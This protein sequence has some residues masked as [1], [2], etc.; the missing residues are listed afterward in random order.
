MTMSLSRVPI[1][2]APLAV[3]VPFPLKKS[4]QYS[5]LRRWP[6]HAETGVHLAEIVP[7]SVSP[8]ALSE[9]QKPRSREFRG[10]LSLALVEAYSAG[11]HVEESCKN[12]RGVHGAAGHLKSV[13]RR[14]AGI[15]SW[16]CLRGDVTEN[17][18][19]GG[20]GARQAGESQPFPCAMGRSRRIEWRRF[21][22]SIR[23]N[24]TASWGDSVIQK[25]ARML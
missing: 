23:W 22:R 4:G 3:S 10:Q 14:R 12:M 8:A 18:L 7:G 25:S 24:P 17:P 19:V 15:R 21:R 9:L 20:E 1:A 16:A 6:R 2:V 11:K 13:F 5:L